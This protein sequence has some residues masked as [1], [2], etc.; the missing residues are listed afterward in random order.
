M[1]VVA[2]EDTERRLRH[3]G[4]IDIAEVRKRDRTRRIR[5]GQCDLHVRDSVRRD[6]DIEQFPVPVRL[7]HSCA[8]FLLTPAV[9]FFFF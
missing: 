1:T 5:V 9:Q 6:R 8:F 3:A 7:L 4:R 2:D